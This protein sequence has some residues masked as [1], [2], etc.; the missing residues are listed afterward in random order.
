MLNVFYTGCSNQPCLVLNHGVRSNVEPST[1]I[2]MNWHH[3]KATSGGCWAR[4][5]SLLSPK[6]CVSLSYY[7]LQGRRGS[8]LLLQI[9]SV[10]LTY[11]IRNSFPFLRYENIWLI[12]T[13]MW[14]KSYDMSILNFGLGSPN[15]FRL[16]LYY[17][18]IP[19]STAIAVICYQVNKKMVLGYNSWHCLLSIIL[20]FLSPSPPNS[21]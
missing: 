3:L 21:L 15:I 13:L 10:F 4:T 19:S 14:Y 17:P 8:A 6:G 12:L 20:L 2:R 5:N 16:G 18:I 7:E 1:L 11:N 9:Q